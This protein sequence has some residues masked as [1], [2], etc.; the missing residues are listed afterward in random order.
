MCI[1]KMTDA[2]VLSASVCLLDQGY[3]KI[4]LN[5]YSI[6]TEQVYADGIKR[7]IPHFGKRH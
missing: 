4:Q 1:L 7:F 5:R 6:R 2:A 3:G